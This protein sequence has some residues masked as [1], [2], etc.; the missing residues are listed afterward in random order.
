MI[1]FPYLA[2]MLVYIHLE[3][4]FLIFFLNFLDVLVNDVNYPVILSYSV[5]PDFIAYCSHVF[6]EH[7]ICQ[8]T[9]SYH[10]TNTLRIPKSF[11]HNMPLYSTPLML[12]K[13]SFHIP[14]VIPYIET[15]SLSI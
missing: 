3:S 5:W 9:G 7:A 10:F 2:C 4:Q 15:E 11:V 14:L 8:D 1:M 6:S 12:F 13:F